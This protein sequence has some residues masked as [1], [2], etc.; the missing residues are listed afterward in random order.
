[1][2]EEMQAEAP[3]PET[4]PD[5]APP[6]ARP[7]LDIHRIEAAQYPH[8][9]LEGITG[10][11]DHF[12]AVIRRATLNEIHRHGKATPEVEICGVLIGNVY[13]DASGPYLFIEACI[14]GDAA[15]NHAAQV[16]FKAETWRKIQEVMDRDFPDGRIVGWYHTHPGFGI[17]LSGMDLFIQDNF[18]NLP[19]Q[20]AFV[21]DP[22]GGD[23]GMFFWHGGK[24]ERGGFLVDETLTAEE[25]IAADEDARQKQLKPVDETPRGLERFALAMRSIQ[26]QY[27]LAIIVGLFLATFFIASAAMTYSHFAGDGSPTPKQSADTRK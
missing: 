19:W 7:E 13:R 27:K 17:F 15:D 22:V 2:S 1:M 21:Y 26:P 3:P 5:T 6:P 12:E 11:K 18:F 24:A 16:T 10:R 20:V 4:V 25:T 14:R 8:R 9:S 23:E